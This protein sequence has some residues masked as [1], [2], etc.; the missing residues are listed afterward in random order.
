MSTAEA[1][2]KS[3]GHRRGGEESL[4]QVLA[5]VR[6]LSVVDRDELRAR[7]LQPRDAQATIDDSDVTSERNSRRGAL[8]R[9]RM[10]ASA[11]GHFN[12]QRLP[13]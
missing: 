2:D 8:I 4:E 13:P 7:V 10:P 9:Q 3:E 1:V 12:A 11:I 6:I 5:H